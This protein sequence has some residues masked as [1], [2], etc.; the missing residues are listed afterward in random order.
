MRKIIASNHKL[1]YRVYGILDS[2]IKLYEKSQFIKLMVQADISEGS[3][4][5]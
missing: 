4:I 2:N 3:T 1:V 5:E